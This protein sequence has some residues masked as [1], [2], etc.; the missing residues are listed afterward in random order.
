MTRRDERRPTRSDFEKKFRAHRKSLLVVTDL[1][2]SAFESRVI[3]N[4]WQPNTD[5][6]YNI[7][8]VLIR[9]VFFLFFSIIRSNLFYKQEMARA[10]LILLL[11]NFHYNSWKFTQLNLVYSNYS[12][13]KMFIYKLIWLR[14]ERNICLLQY[15]RQTILLVSGH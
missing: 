6:G 9:L 15:F 11:N 8:H 12:V 14:W 1:C 2:S 10:I 4:L 5:V 13:W 7:V 3:I